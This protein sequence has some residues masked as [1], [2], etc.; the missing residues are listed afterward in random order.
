MGKLTKFFDKVADALVPKE[1]AP[2]L[3][4]AA[5]MFAGPLG[6]PL[7]L[8]L[9]QL[10]SAKMHSGK[11][12]PYTALGTVLSAQG[13]KA[14]NPQGYGRI[15]SGLKEGLGTFLPGGASPMD[16][17]ASFM[18]GY[19]NP[20]YI[21]GLNFQ[22][23]ALDKQ[24]ANLA[25]SP[26]QGS[27]TYSPLTEKE[28]EAIASSESFFG[29]G[30]TADTFTQNVG[31][32]LFPGFTDPETDKFDL[33]R[34]LTTIGSTT[35]LSQVMPLAEELKKQQMK[36]EQEEGA[37]WQSWFESYKKTTGR[38]YGDSPYPDPEI[39]RLWNKYGKP[40]GLAMGGRVGYNDGGDTGIIAAAP[41]MPKGMQLDG[42]DGIFVSQGIEE[43]ADDVPAMLSKNEFVLT[44]DAMKG[45]DK[46]T[47]GAGNPRAAAQKMYQFMDQMEAIA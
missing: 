30:G 15:G 40:L 26:K 17:G 23:D 45:F 27:P 13:Y 25:S 1:I 31:E 9:G 39:T 47:G 43:K 10:G 34:A 19:N 29:P 36:D 16:F 4:P 22:Q 24:A 44:A 12:D 46:M 28:L 2:F 18:E 8:G 42:R 14:R 37:A 5:M 6:M 41:G 20:G 35:T 33:T 32:T 38:S 21:Q 3:G 7:A 11:L